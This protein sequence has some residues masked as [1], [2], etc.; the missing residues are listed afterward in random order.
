MKAIVSGA[1]GFIG[2][3]LARYLESTGGLVCRL[4]RRTPPGQALSHSF[5]VALGDPLPAVA[6]TGA[7][8]LYHLAY[9]LK[10]GSERS[11][12]EGTCRWFEQARRQGIPRQ[13]FLS[14]YSALPGV[15]SEYGRSKYALERFFL[16]NN[17]CVVRPGWVVGDG[18]SF[19]RWVASILRWPWIVVPGGDRLRVA[20][21]DIDHLI[22]VLARPDALT[23]GRVFNIFTGDTVGLLTLASAV[24]SSVGR[25]GKTI[26]VPFSLSK[27][28]AQT[29]AVVVPSFRPARDSLRALEYSQSSGLSSTVGEGGGEFFSW[30]RVLALYVKNTHHHSLS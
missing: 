5:Q 19:G 2:A 23:P 14:S 7:D 1:N 6:L 9:D 15:P 27:I 24:R 20:L 12:I 18:G 26:G 13:V 22:R 11:N 17:Q 16:E 29:V 3:R 25:N 28:I 21:T 4:F 10:T 30:E 8:V